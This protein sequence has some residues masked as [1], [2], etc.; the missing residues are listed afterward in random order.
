MNKRVN[1]VIGIIL[2]CL[3]PSV[4]VSISHAQEFS[5]MNFWTIGGLQKGE[6]ISSI[7]YNPI[8]G[9]DKDLEES[10][11]FERTLDSVSDNTMIFKTS[12]FT[13]GANI[14]QKHTIEVDMRTGG[15]VSVD[16]ERKDGRQ[17]EFFMDTTGYDIGTKINFHG[18]QYEIIGKGLRGL[19]YNGYTV[20][21]PVFRATREYE[22]FQ[23]LDDF[24][25][26]TLY[27]HHTIMFSQ[28]SGT[29][30]TYGITYVRTITDT[31]EHV[32]T[33]FVEW[34]TKET[35]GLTLL[36]PSETPTIVTKT[37]TVTITE[38][39]EPEEKPMQEFSVPVL[40][41]CVLL[42]ALLTLS[43]RRKNK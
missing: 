12:S 30:L 1:Y 41:I 9:E 8:W 43:R 35:Y 21:I 32:M 17:W 42:V 25:N 37:E 20:N 14:P 26:C 36:P 7:F 39:V 38:T 24:G 5:G 34:E 40:G 10:G 11:T 6:E 16:G 22:E 13:Y 2:L 33:H 27:I 31:G 3:V 29:T 18:E 15:L 23:T 19:D 28:Y 4:A